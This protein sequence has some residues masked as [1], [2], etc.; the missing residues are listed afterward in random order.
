MY[1]WKIPC[2]PDVSVHLHHV[3]FARLERLE[4]VMHVLHPEEYCH[5][6]IVGH[7]IVARVICGV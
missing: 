1:E 6:R 2:P 3:K 4:K 5:D 7:G